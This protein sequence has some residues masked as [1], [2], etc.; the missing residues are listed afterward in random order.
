MYACV[1]VC[2]HVCVCVRVCVCVCVCMR[3]R[4]RVCACVRGCVCV[5]VCVCVMCACVGALCVCV[6][7]YMCVCICMRINMDYPILKK[8]NSELNCFFLSRHGRGQFNNTSPKNTSGGCGQSRHTTL[9][10]F[11]PEEMLAYSVRKHISTAIISTQSLDHCIPIHLGP[12]EI[13][14]MFIYLL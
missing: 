13:F 6:Y 12:V 9:C 11:C 4:M 3:V 10:L 5:C 14:N 8:E 1:C 7:I 2:M